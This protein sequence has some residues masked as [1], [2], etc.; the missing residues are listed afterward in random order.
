[1]RGVYPAADNVG[2]RVDLG[3]GRVVRIGT[4]GDPAA[5]PSWI[6]DQLIRHSESHLAYSHQSGF[7]PDIAMQSA[8]T[9]AQAQAHWAHGNRTFRVIA[10]LGELIKGKEILCPASK[11]AGQRVQCNACKLCGGTSV[12]ASKSIAIVQH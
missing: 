5:V 11:E 4:Y 6:W 3:T 7:R 1:M 10:D 9:E 12:K 2:D 8:D